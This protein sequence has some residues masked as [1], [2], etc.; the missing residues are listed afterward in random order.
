LT[1]QPVA[2]ILPH[3]HISWLLPCFT[4]PMTTPTNSFEPG[5]HNLFSVAGR[6]HEEISCGPQTFYL[7]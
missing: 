6:S 4:D 3:K 2:N 5:L 7:T 1:K